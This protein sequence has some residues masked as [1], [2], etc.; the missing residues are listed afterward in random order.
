MLTRGSSHSLKY[1]PRIVSDCMK[2]LGGCTGGR[3]GETLDQVEPGHGDKQAGAG[4][5][6]IEK[7]VLYL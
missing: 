3:G 2:P 4:I 7:E 6:N 5:E 1:V